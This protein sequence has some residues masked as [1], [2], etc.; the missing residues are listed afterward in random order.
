M[1]RTS[2]LVLATSLAL[3][4]AL[5]LGRHSALAAAPQR[6][7]Q[8]MGEAGV[9]SPD[10]EL[11]RWTESIARL[12]PTTPVPKIDTLSG[13]LAKVV[14]ALRLDGLDLSR[15]ITF[16]LLNP[17]AFPQP[18]VLVG[19]AA[20]KKRLD[21]S[22]AA[23]PVLSSRVK[24]K[25]VAIGSAAALAHAA[26]Y[27]FARLHAAPARGAHAVA[28][29]DTILGTFGGQIQMLKGLIM[30][31]PQQ[32]GS[33]MPIAQLAAMY[34][35]MLNGLSQSSELS[36]DVG[37]Q[38]GVP[39][40]TLALTAK[41]GT[42][43]D[44]FIANQKPS[45]FSLLNKLPARPV[46]TIFAGRMGLGDSAGAL[47]DWFFSKDTLDPAA[48]ADLLEMV[49]VM[50]GEVAGAG[51]LSAPDQMELSYLIGATD[52]G[53]ALALL[54]RAHEIFSKTG[55]FG[56]A[57]KVRLT[58]APMVDYDG[59]K[60]SQSEFHYDFSKLAGYKGKPQMDMHAAWA[61]WDKLVGLAMGTDALQTIHQL[62]DSARH[63]TATYTPTGT[64]RTSLERARSLKESMWMRMDMAAILAAQAKA[65]QGKDAIPAWV[66]P[67]IGL[68]VA[69][70][71]IHMRIA[72][73]DPL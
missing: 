35:G 49:K 8:V 9:A 7:A 45:D 37:I 42:A 20:N 1:T 62:V 40:L 14:G 5:V 71:A 22:L 27:A 51:N 4:G 39:E 13:G 36:F 12:S 52:V 53:R 58:P 68:G 73:A 60:V 38:S 70:H 31:Q 17:M 25:L 6:P 2:R 10:A 66:A 69:G 46:S 29:L 33:P 47:L 43:I 57:A 26:E 44:Q 64:V 48:R 11:L 55:L 21:E 32:P 16:V 18:V 3:T 54:P 72:I 67:A 63:G 61:G 56:G 30:A 50:N 24:G 65:T 28:F 19:Q 59:L 34:D 41:P 15:P 23:T